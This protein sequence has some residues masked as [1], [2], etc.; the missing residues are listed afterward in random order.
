MSRL[1]AISDIHGCSKTFRSLIE[2]TIRLEKQDSLYLLGDYIDR[3]ADSKGVL[4]HILELIS[5]KYDIT[6]LRGNHEEM[7]L[8]SLS[9][10]QYLETWVFNGGDKTLESFHDKSS[11]LLPVKYLDFIRSM[12]HYK[13]IERFILVHAGIDFDRPD[14]FEDKES[15][16]WLRHFDVDK[17][18]AGGRAVIHGHTPVSREKIKDS[19]SKVSEDKNINIDNGCV[20]K[21]NN[22][23]GQ[24]CALELNTLELFFHPN[25][26]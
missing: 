11:P 10:P 13:I 26:D 17:V 25:I 16:L 21:S 20:Y 5:Q 24:L 1:F 14:P 9:D 22:S 18:K 4:D 23:L 12:G 6:V 15:M 3:G 2:N 19:I 8:K 7:L